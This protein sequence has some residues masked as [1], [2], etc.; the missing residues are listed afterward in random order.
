MK[1]NALAPLLLSLLSLLP[2][3]ALAQTPDTATVKALWE[4]NTI[5]C[6][7][8]HGKTGEG[9]FGPDLAGRGLSAAQFQRAVRKPWGVM[10]AFAEEQI[11]D[12]ELTALAA[13]FASLPKPAEPGPWLTPVNPDKPHA[14]Q[15][16]A[17][18][19]C[20]QCHGPVPPPNF[21]GQVHEFELLKRLV[22][23]HTAEMP[24]LEPL[25]P[26]GRYAM[27]NFNP[28]RLSEAQLKELF[29]WATAPR[30]NK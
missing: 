10:P 15:L 23:T 21:D 3:F 6:K 26:G 20:G 22:Y 9:A 11:S 2:C 24:K 5:F 4:S 12:A 17:S 13:Y 29:D 27:G 14:Q 7:N 1:K 25:K 30:N 8:C 19:G 28:L 18:L 16:F